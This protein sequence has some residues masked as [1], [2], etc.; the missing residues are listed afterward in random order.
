ML[1]QETWL[2]ENEN[3][4]LYALS[5]DFFA[6]GVYA[7]DPS[8]KL[9]SGRPFGGLAVLWRRSIAPQCK[10]HT[11]DDTRIM[12]IS[13]TS[14]SKQILILNVYMP[15][16][17]GSNLD[18]YLY[19][20]GKIED[21]IDSFQS[22]YVYVCG[23]FNANINDTS[24]RF[25]Q[26]LLEFC[27][28][29]SLVMS[30]KEF[31]GVN[32]SNYTYTSDAHGTNA[33]IDHILASVSAHDIIDTIS[34]NHSFIT[35]DHAP[36]NMTITC[37]DLLYEHNDTSNASVESALKSRRIKWDTLSHEELEQYR[38]DTDSLL[39]AVHFDHS[40]MLCDDVQCKD[41]C[42]H[43][44]IDRLFK[45]LQDCLMEAS[46]KLSSNANPSFPQIVGWNDI[47][48]DAHSLARDSFLAWVRS[49]R[50]KQGTAFVEMTRAR[51]H[52]KL[53]LRQCRLD[54]KSNTKDALA[55]KLLSKNPKDFWKEV[56][57]S[58]NTGQTPLASTVDGA[59]GANNI[60]KMWEYYFKNLLNSCNDFSNSDFVKSQFD[61]LSCDM[62]VKEGFCMPTIVKESI[63]KLKPGKSVGKD[64]ISGEHFIYCG[65]RIYVLLSLLFNCC[66]SH[67]HLPIEL[68]DTIIVPLIKDKKGDISDKD[69]YRPIALTCIMSKV[70]E[71]VVLSVTEDCLFTSSNQFGFKKGMSTDKCVYS[72]KQVTE[73]Y[74]LHGSPVYLSFLDAS[75]AFDKINHWTL[76]KKLL[77]RKLPICIVRLLCVWYSTQQFYVLWGSSL[78]SSFTVTNGVRQGGILSPI[79]FNVYM[80]DLSKILCNSNI[81]CY[82]NE[83]CVNH[84]LYAD[85][86]VLISPSPSG[87]QKLVNLCCSYA[88]ANDITFNTKKTKLMCF[89]PKCHK[90]LFV[91]QISLNGVVI[92]LVRT[93]K[94]LG[95][96]FSDDMKDDCDIKRQ[97]RTLYMQG[98]SII[99]CFRH[100]STE[101]KCLLF[102]T[103][104]TSFYCPYL[105]KDFSSECFRRLKVAYNRIFRHLFNITQYNP[106]LSSVTS[107]SHVMV[108]NNIQT[109]GAVI[110]RYIHGF[111][112]RLNTCENLI[113]KGILCS[114]FFYSSSLFKHWNKQLY[115]PP[116]M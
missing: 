108:K 109:F 97:I 75:K 91:P 80:D 41:V 32:P 3:K 60:S 66:I 1:L 68:L 59:T 6:R 61:K 12:G 48:K 39:A 63:K 15:Y 78:S 94:Y 76:F 13:I 7:M 96:I 74:N 44:S 27:E 16:Y 101:V 45:E 35:S 88:L 31:L 92:D 14:E 104:C 52:F 51:A 82:V 9:L 43:A 37:G 100:C 34:I 116:Q 112:N 115:M 71:H 38:I 70:F 28:D 86:T 46:E 72:L 114:V 110:R 50:P 40:L 79:L 56:R 22:P 111:I 57:A 64:G 54:I 20:L 99:K 30:D 85:D 26:Q 53:V 67:G 103:F 11:Y 106:L 89:K 113:V 84:L 33:W 47:C 5:D 55:K 17:D 69:N 36:M 81:G 102:K 93:Y 95:V 19:Y 58:N 90:D 65:E 105:W 21:I 2:A 10:V 8:A 77:Q 25:G 49:N 29:S 23:D 98:N 24:S 107:I 4:I 42:H 73:Y 87:L 62:S 83:T 18:D